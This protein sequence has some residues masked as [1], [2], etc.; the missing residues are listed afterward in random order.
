M[1][2]RVD[3]PL[4]RIG[5]RILTELQ[6]DPRIPFSELGRRVGLSPPAVAERVRRLQDAGI[7]AGFRVDLGL[8]RLG[9]GVT[10]LVRVSAPETHCVALGALVRRLPGVIEGWRVTG[11]DRLVVRV[12]ATTVADLDAI[13]REI[14]RYGTATVSVV[15]RSFVRGV[16]RPAV[17]STNGGRRQPGGRAGHA[18][19]LTQKGRQSLQARRS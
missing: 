11:E 18:S 4:D 19:E 10:A 7:I 16:E 6:A 17:Q 5:W 9:F 2:S 3:G 14:S 13:V 1:R 8:D 12:A 15:L